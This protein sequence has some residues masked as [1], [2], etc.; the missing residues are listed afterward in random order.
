MGLVFRRLWRTF[1]WFGLFVLA[2]S[3]VVL[4]LLGSGNLIWN[5]TLIGDLRPVVLLIVGLGVTA[6]VWG[7]YEKSVDTNPYRRVL[8]PLLAS[9]EEFVLLLRPFGSDGE[10]F[11]RYVRGGSGKLRFVPLGNVTPTLTLEQVVAAAARRQLGISAYAMVDQGETL[12]APGPIYLRAPHSEWKIP[13]SALIRRAHTIA[14][15]L[16]PGQELRRALEWELQEIIRWRRQSRVLIVLPPSDRREYGHAEL[17][18]QAGILMAALEGLPS[19]IANVPKDRVEHYLK[20]I[21]DDVL[22]V[23]LRSDGGAL[24]WYSDR[25][26]WRK[27]ASDTYASSLAEALAANEKEFKGQGFSARYGRIGPPRLR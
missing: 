5:S 27:V 23:K 12:A 15:L 24:F 3:I 25:R 9:R 22:V 10:V 17:R 4:V 14:I 11:V 26:R 13:A 2:F 18:R 1:G 6:A 21:P 8:D 20:E 16:P 19:G 7:T